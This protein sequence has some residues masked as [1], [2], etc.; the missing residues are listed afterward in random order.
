ML[1]RL[2][3]VLLAA[4]LP[5]AA[6]AEY[7]M[8][9]YDPATTYRTWSSNQFFLRMEEKTGVKF[10]Y[11]QYTDEDEWTK[12]KAAMQAGSADLP[13]VL[14]KASLKNSEC[15]DL[16]ER[17]VLVDLKPYLAECCPNLMALL[18]EYPEYEQAI[19]LPGGAIAALPSINR[20]PMQNCVWLNREWMNT[21]GL[22]MPT[23]AEELTDLLRAFRDQ[24]PNR[25]GKK[26]EI[27]LAF[28]GAFDLKFL[29]HAYGLTA[30]DYNLRA[31]DGKAEFVPLAEEFRPFVT[32][33]RQLFSEGL[34]DPQGFMTTDSLRAVEKD[35]DTN[36][37]GG[38]IT[39]V[40]TNFLPAAWIKNYTVMM[41]L[42]YEGKSVYRDFGG[43][44]IGGT[45]AITT[46]C[47]NVP[48]L[49][50]WVDSFY[51]EEVYIMGSAGLENIDYVIDGDGTWRMTTAATN[52]SYFTGDTL[53]TSGTTVPGVVDE[54][55]QRRYYDQ[56]VNQLS[57]EIARI[58]DVA[59]RPFPYFAL[60][61]EQ[62]SY[63]A[64]LQSRIGR[65]VDE[66]V[67]RWVLGEVPISDE[68]FADFEAQLKEA[69]LDDFMAFWQGILE[70]LNP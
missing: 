20:Q 65:L 63:I 48:E 59:S 50:K 24:D 64:P 2:L 37:Y 19:T 29:G 18:A 21:L 1:K 52:N 17:G 53:I 9:G 55:F 11:K 5:C 34:L 39:T 70:G 33:L 8:A 46:A 13:D 28:L 68:S 15:L 42:T 44:L 67:A 25:N 43:G 4:L 3:C 22:T 31:V 58:N 10:T 16:L 30:N 51:T 47:D 54:T 45:F 61:A 36:V 7:T 27:P 60:T 56:T 40:V 38:T 49:L 14:F 26:D 41:P 12:A 66:S 23:T 62:A 6:L 69:G 35:T 57:D 32:W